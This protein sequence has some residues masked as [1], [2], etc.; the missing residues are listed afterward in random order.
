MVMTNGPAL[1]YERSWDDGLRSLVSISIIFD[2]IDPTHCPS[3][4]SFFMTPSKQQ[5]VSELLSKI[6]DAQESKKRA[7]LLE[8]LNGLQPPISALPPEI[9]SIIFVY[10]FR[11]PHK[12]LHRT[13]SLVSKRWRRVLVNTPEVWTTVDLD[14]SS[15]RGGM[16][17]LSFIANSSDRTLSVTLR[18]RGPSDK[19]GVLVSPNVD[20]R[21]AE[22]FGRIQSL[23][24]TNP[25]ISWFSQLPQLQRMQSLTLKGHQGPRVPTNIAVDRIPS[26]TELALVDLKSVLMYSTCTNL[27]SLTLT[28][29]RVTTSVRIFTKCPNL[30]KL[31]L[32]YL[33]RVQEGS[34]LAGVDGEDSNFP[35][36]TVSLEHLETFEWFLCKPEDIFVLSWQSAIWGHL[37]LPSLRS[38]K[39]VQK[40]ELPRPPP[41][42]TFFNRS[43][44]TLNEVEFLRVTQ[45]GG[46][47][48]DDSFPVEKIVFEDCV[49]QFVDVVLGD[50]QSPARLP[51]LKTVE[52]KGRF[53]DRLRQK[54]LK[55]MTE[56]AKASGRGI[57][58]N[59]VSVL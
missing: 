20:S 14:V 55:L 26:L 23:H 37:N 43:A 19:E 56:R 22:S 1:G 38:M 34:I 18:F 3:I 51:K 39:W 49:P 6:R 28:Q 47:V 9:L 12:R 59:G 32:E 35:N 33:G 44:L 30:K 15:I 50:I 7:E 11:S 17:L 4:V 25:P 2:L 10:A 27:T 54:H 21:I 24:L 41:M 29:L 31:H 46:T 13:I 16:A 5:E 8:E 52:M 53:L 58:F 45:S 36:R 40:G 42:N 48:F 57:V